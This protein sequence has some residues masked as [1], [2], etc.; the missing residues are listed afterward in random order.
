MQVFSAN[1]SLFKSGQIITENQVQKNWD[2]WFGFP[3]TI[4]DPFLSANT[5]VETNN[6]LEEIELPWRVSTLNIVDGV[7]QWTI[8]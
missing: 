1:Y 7:K 5:V 2:L 3:E 4:I 6:Y 8:A